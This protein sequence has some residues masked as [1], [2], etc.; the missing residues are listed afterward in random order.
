MVRDAVALAQEP[1]PEATTRAELRHLLPEVAEDVEVEGQAASAAVR[2]QPPVERSLE[3]G[4]SDRQAVG[5]LLGGVRPGLTDV[6][7]ADADRAVL[8]GVVRAE[9][10]GVDH[11]PDRVLDRED[12]GPA[13]DELLE[14][15]V[16]GGA[17]QPGEVVAALAGHREVHRHDG[18]GRAV[19]GQRHRDRVQIDAGEGLFHVG[20]GV[21][22]HAYA[23]DLAPSHGVIRVQ[24]A[25]GGQVEGDVEARVAVLEQ[26]EEAL[27]GLCG[28]AEAGVLAD[29]PGTG[30]VH[31]AV[32]AAGEGVLARFADTLE[33]AAVLDIRGVVDGLDL[34][35]ALPLQGLDLLAHEATSSRMKATICSKSEPVG[36][37]PATP[38]ASSAA[39]SRRGTLPPTI[40]TSSP[41]SPLAWSSWRT[42]SQSG[43]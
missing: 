9:L 25:L 20:E 41:N 34:Q 18:A 15:V 33:A 14:D 13:A 38:S 16:L 42:P 27:V 29:G 30:P 19:D 6:V 11:Q 28:G 24:P 23:A 36:K 32:D 10:H 1:G 2:V 7:A 8:G 26:V 17:A 40:Q 12:P 4:A 22:R 35:A 31:V 43:R 39:K 5:H 37:T 3:V 21:H